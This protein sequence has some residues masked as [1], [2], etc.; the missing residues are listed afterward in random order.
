MK[1][2]TPQLNLLCTCLAILAGAA[3]FAASREGDEKSIFISV[4]DTAGQPA[5]GLTAADFAIREDGVDREIV[6]AKLSSEPL[7]VALLA[8][9][10]GGAARHVQPIRAGLKAFI[11]HVLAANAGSRVALWEFGEAPRRLTDFTDDP[12]KLG[13]EVGRLFPRSQSGSFLLDTIHD[14]SQ[15]LSRTESKRRAIVVLSVDPADEQSQQDPKKIADVM[16]RSRA[17]LW[18]LSL[19]NGTA[20]NGRQDLIINMFMRNA[21]GRRDQIVSDTGIEAGMRRLATM[22]TTQYELTYRRPSGAAKVVQT[23]IRRDGLRIIA[24]LVAPQ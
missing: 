14:V 17:Q 21:G 19:Q 22:L 1:R 12:A 11:D 4:V 8:D 18:G 13:K 7:H 15:A 23:G 9:T 6:S 5:S 10:T 24:G 3:T 16:A 2:A 20:Q